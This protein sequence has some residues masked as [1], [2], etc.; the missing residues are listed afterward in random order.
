MSTRSV[1]EFTKGTEFDTNEDYLPP[2]QRQKGEQLTPASPVDKL[3][4]L[5]R[6]A[7]MFT[8]GQRVQDRFDQAVNWWKT[9][10]QERR[11]RRAAQRER[12]GNSLDNIA[13]AIIPFEEAHEW[14]QEGHVAQQ[15]PHR[16][17]VYQSRFSGTTEQA[18][19]HPKIDDLDI[20]EAAV[21][22]A[23][24]NL[25][26]LPVLHDAPPVV[27]G[28]QDI[29]DEIARLETAYDQ[30]AVEPDRRHHTGK[31]RMPEDDERLAT[32]HGK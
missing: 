16:P 21:K 28:H 29:A 4:L 2:H 25:G 31:H 17:G 20:M 8:D 18:P 6:V 7:Q 23:R 32:T 30:P 11:V 9:K 24:A 3:R 19:A 15:V 26:K 5:G 10:R 1:N 14:R 27:R 13:G 12:E 22:R